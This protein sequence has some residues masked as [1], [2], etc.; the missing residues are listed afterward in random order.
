M[1]ETEIYPNFQPISAK[2]ATLGH[3]PAHEVL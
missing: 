3:I 2:E 1:V